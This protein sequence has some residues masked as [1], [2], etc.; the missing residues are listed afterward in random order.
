MRCSERAHERNECATAAKVSGAVISYG[1]IRIERCGRQLQLADNRTGLSS[2]LEF[3]IS[4][5]SHMLAPSPFSLLCAASPAC[6]MRVHAWHVHGR[7]AVLPTPTCPHSIDRKNGVSPVHG[8]R[9][10][11][12]ETC[13]YVLVETCCTH[14]PFAIVRMRCLCPI[15]DSETS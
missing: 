10:V 15:Y 7:H 12:R 13:R 3:G 8:R 9:P 14:N 5:S 4:G 1:R 6:P 11:T 2:Y